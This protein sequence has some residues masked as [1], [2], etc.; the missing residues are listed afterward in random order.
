MGEWYKAQKKVAH[1]KHIATKLSERG[2]SDVA[3]GER[4]LKRGNQDVSTAEAMLAKGKSDVVAAQQATEK[5]R[6]DVATAEYML[7]RA[8]MDEDAARGIRSKGYSDQAAA[9][10]IIEAVNSAEAAFHEEDIKKQH[11]AEERRRKEMGE[12]KR[13]QD[14]R[15]LL[16]EKEAHALW[17]RHQV[18]KGVSDG[19]KSAMCKCDN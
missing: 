8:R 17:Q 6:Q 12:V 18:G 14:L 11:N 1:A 2:N 9:A 16:R 15:R 19:F 4:M 10:K 5:A 13:A 7:R 3:S